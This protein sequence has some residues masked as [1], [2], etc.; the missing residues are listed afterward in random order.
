MN[1]ELTEERI[2]ELL[3]EYIAERQ[4]KPIDHEDFA[5]RHPP[6][7]ERLLLT[8]PTVDRLYGFEPPTPKLSGRR[9]GDFLIGEE[10]GRGGMGIV[11]AAHQSSLGRPV[12]L[13]VL[14][15][16]ATLD[17]N[18][19]ARFSIE[20]HAAASLHH[21]HIVPVHWFGVVDDVHCYAMARIDGRS[22]EDEQNAGDPG[23]VAIGRACRLIAD[24]ADALH[25]AHDR[26]VI[27]RD[28]KPSNL[29]IDVEDKIWITDF[30]LA[31][32][33]QRSDVSRTGEVV[34]SRRTMSPEQAAGHPAAVDHRSD[35]YSL[36]ATLYRWLTGVD[37]RPAAD[38]GTGTRSVIVPPRRLR[39]E[40]S[41]DLQTILLTA[42]AHDP[43]DR[44]PSAADLANDLR[45]MLAGRP[46]TAR[47][48]TLL[49]RG[50]KWAARHRMAVA[51][52]ASLLIIALTGSL[53]MT[54]HLTHQ[55]AQLA[56]ALTEVQTQRQLAEQRFEQTRL[57]LDRFGLAAAEGLTGIA[58][59]QP[60]RQSLVAD[61]LGYYEQ[62]VQS[63]HGDVTLESQRAD[64]YL[65]AAEILDQIGQADKATAAAQRAL[66]IFK[67][68]A[69]GHALQL[70]RCHH[71][72]GLLSAEAGR[73]EDAEKHYARA[74]TG[75]DPGEHLTRAKWMGDWAMLDQARGHI[76]S[77][78]LR[79]DNAIA[80]LSDCLETAPTNSTPTPISAAGRQTPGAP[81]GGPHRTA[82]KE[83]T[84]EDA[85][86]T[87]A[88]LLS[89]RAAL[90]DNLTFA[91]DQTQ[92]ALDALNTVNDPGPVILSSIAKTSANHAV[93]LQRADRLPE[94]HT[95]YANAAG[96]YDQLLEQQPT[97][98][99]W[100]EAL[101]M[102][103]NNWARLAVEQRDLS[104]ANDHLDAASEHLRWLARLRPRESRYQ[105]ALAAL[106]SNRRQLTSARQHP[107]LG[108]LRLAEQ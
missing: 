35:I 95:A 59:A 24:A 63:D 23:G 10:I 34:G 58:G 1:A 84:H 77:S 92:A 8:L 56:I 4:I 64:T 65:R 12:A 55:R 40:L 101:A 28:I 41:S 105:N 61:V 46:I 106:Q 38:W 87:L 71:R 3:D 70:A 45:R 96:Q 52:A 39:R 103:H 27:H 42:I 30:G 11:Y 60:L 25:H 104:S 69:S 80:D 6:H 15:G 88:M 75:L 107:S 51:T 81:P 74:T 73:Y 2:V 50:S 44:Y 43:A 49:D 21:P 18:Q 5:G 22:I 78:K 79:I 7:A 47:P 57:V 54:T 14:P 66:R 31:R 76:E 26:G 53:V 90:A 16:P 72:L 82:S 83:S 36:G 100:T 102:L 99:H 32:I 86:L 19:V 108:G 67:I 29:M 91:I 13:K 98:V 62:F 9:L 97:A 93:L 33:G 68:N 85:I 48:P 89:Q 37:C 17:E 20:A 94:A